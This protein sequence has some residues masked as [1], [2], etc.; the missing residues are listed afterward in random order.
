MTLQLAEKPRYTSVH[1]Y[2]RKANNVRPHRRMLNEGEENPNP[3]IYL[4]AHLTGAQTGIYVRED[5]FDDLSPDEWKSMMWQL[6]PFQHETQVKGMSETAQMADR[7]SRKKRRE[8]RKKAKVDKKGAK[9][10]IKKAKAEAIRTGKRAEMFSNIFKS[11]GDTVKSV[12]PGG[13]AG[14]AIDAMSPGGSD[15]T[16]KYADSSEET[17]WYKNPWVIGGGILGV[18]GLVYVGTRGR[19]RRR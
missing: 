9:N 19:R 5:Y 1:G 2:R 15:T 6:A 14:A 13:A 16:G 3:Y 11:V 12:M 8:E 7:A 4:P 10:E 18:A 17:P